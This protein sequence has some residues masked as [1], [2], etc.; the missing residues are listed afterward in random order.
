MRLDTVGLDPGYWTQGAKNSE[1]FIYRGEVMRSV[2]PS[3]AKR[4]S[5]LLAMMLLAMACLVAGCGSTSS[6]SGN[7][8]GSGNTAK[9][10]SAGNPVVSMAKQAASQ[11][12]QVPQSIGI[13]ANV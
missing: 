10:G 9:S 2:R 5:A 7:T 12:E 11:Y 3:R 8:A 13:T 1:P 4:W 6:N